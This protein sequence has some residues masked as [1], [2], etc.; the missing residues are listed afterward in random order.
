[1]GWKSQWKK[2]RK[3]LKIKTNLEVF[4]IDFLHQMHMFIQAEQFFLCEQVD[5]LKIVDI[6]QLLCRFA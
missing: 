1:M 5:L 4:G 3:K 2:K 6:V